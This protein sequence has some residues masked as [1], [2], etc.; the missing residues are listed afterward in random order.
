MDLC[1]T[2]STKVVAQE[3]DLKNTTKLYANIYTKLVL[4]MKKLQDN[5]KR[6]KAKRRPV[7]IESSSS[8]E[9]DADDDLGDSP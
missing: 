4:K 7:V 9:S 2:L 5:V 6:L 1:T 8:F 3:T